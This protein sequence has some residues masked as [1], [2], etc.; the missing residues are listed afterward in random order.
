MSEMIF[1]AIKDSLV[2]FPFL[3]LVYV[4]MEIIEGAKNKDRIER[5]LSGSFAP[6]AAAALGIVPECGMSAMFSKLYSDGYIT[7][8]TLIAAFI[9]TSDEGLIVLLSSG[10]P[11]KDIGLI[12]LYKILFG[13]FFGLLIN[14]A[15]RRFKREHVCPKRGDCIECGEHH[16]GVFDTLIFHP[17]Y[18]AAKTFLYILAIN[19]VLGFIIYSLGEQNV[20]LFLRRGEGLQPLLA[21]VVGIV[22]NCASSIILAR[23]YVSGFL[24]FS[25]LMAG[26]CAN[27]G[28][29]L[30]IIFKDK[31]GLKKALSVAATLFVSAVIIGYVVYFIS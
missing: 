25:G 7:A 2:V 5:A 24:S 9:S 30:L 21:A 23:G 22:P 26:L 16:E 19:L 11:I 20:E 27:S 3:F 29:G 12:I 6:F 10:V 13:L 28:I 15:T 4:L 31:K 8:G 18:H 1:D 14:T 17:F